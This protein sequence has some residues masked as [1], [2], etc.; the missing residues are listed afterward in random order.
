MS[1]TRFYSISKRGSLPHVCVPKRPRRE[2][3]TPTHKHPTAGQTERE[4][5]RE[6]GRETL[7]HVNNN[8]L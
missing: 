5:E 3:D 2:G 6:R 7:Q 4:E 1:I 8:I